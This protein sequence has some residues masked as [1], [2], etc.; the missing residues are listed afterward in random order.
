MKSSA[1]LSICNAS[2][3]PDRARWKHAPSIPDNVRSTAALDGGDL[4]E[5]ADDSLARDFF[6]ENSALQCR[7]VLHTVS[8]NPR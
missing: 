7:D 3:S 5:A 6:I 1:S 2:P 8:R 4:E